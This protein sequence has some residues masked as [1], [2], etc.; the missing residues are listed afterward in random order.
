M[1]LTEQIKTLHK[2]IDS[3]LETEEYDKAIEIIDKIITNQITIE[4]EFVNYAKVEFAS[5]Y[6][7][8]ADA[9]IKKGNKLEESDKLILKTFGVFNQLS[10][11]VPEMSSFI[12]CNRAR[13]LMVRYD[14]AYINKQLKT[15]NRVLTFDDIDSIYLIKD[16]LSEAIRYYWEALKECEDEN[17]Q[18]NIRNNLANGLSRVGRSIEAST[19]LRK[20]IGLMPERWQSHLSWVDALGNLV[21]A[22]LIPETPS[23]HLFA[24]DSYIMVQKTH[25]PAPIKKEVEGRM[26]FHVNRLADHGQVVT[27]TILEKNRVEEKEDF[28]KHT[29]YRKFVLLNDLSLSEHSLYCKCRD[30]SS[31]NLMIGTLGGSSHLGKPTSFPILDGLV[32]RLISEFSFSRLLYF[33]YISGISLTA[34]DVQFSSVSNSDLTGYQIEQLRTSYRIAY[35]ILDKIKNGVSILFETDSSKS[36]TSYFEDYFD[37]CKAELD[38]KR[39]R[40]LT[41][42]YSLALDLNRQHGSF[43]HFKEFRNEMEHGFL[44][45][46]ES[47]T[48]TGLIRMSQEEIKQLTFDLLKLTRSAIFSFVFLVRTT[49]IS[50]VV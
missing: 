15:G 50:A 43:K 24:L 41:A 27:D 37:K 3:F 44:A 33:H 1:Y 12:K 30:A 42:L 5:L 45:V 38:S 9:T 29:E 47:S 13:G 14:I 19:L 31:D 23:M 22:A 2:K 26:S 39:N 35:G 28:D 40:H 16:T 36:K 20:N 7:E 18:Y 49:T 11:Q 6:I 48:Q 25:L 21:D 17:E 4:D 32:N 10:E 46:N 34:D 8:V